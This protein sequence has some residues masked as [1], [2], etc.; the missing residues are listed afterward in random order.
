VVWFIRHL[1]GKSYER[2]WFS[3]RMLA[4][5][6]LHRGGVRSDGLPLRF[7]CNRLE[8]EWLARDIHP[9]YQN[10]L[11]V[12]ERAKLFAEQ[13]LA[14]ADAAVDRLLTALPE[15]DVIELRVLDPDSSD[16]ILTGSVRRCDVSKSGFPSPGMKLKELGCRYRLNNWRF[17]PLN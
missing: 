17:E 8:I 13:C 16:L 7:C 1:L 5:L 15:V 9:W 4:A 14:D 12:V 2:R 10:S 3:N 6:A 11:G